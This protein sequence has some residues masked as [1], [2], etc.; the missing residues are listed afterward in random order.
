MVSV[1]SDRYPIQRHGSRS[2]ELCD[3]VVRDAADGGGKP[4]ERICGVAL[5]RFDQGVG[6]GRGFAAYLGADEGVVLSPEGDGAHAAFGRVVVEFKDAVV[7]VWAQA[8]HA[9][10]RLSDC[11][12]QRDFAR[13]RSELHRQPSFQI[14][15]DRIG[16]GPSQ[17][18]ATIRRG[19]SGL[20]L[21]GIKLGYPADGLFGNRGAL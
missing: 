9:R 16:M 20:F 8:V 3:I 10:Q 14:V 1:R 5:G 15:E 12:G 13:D 4:C 11:S 19:A 2:S 17:F 18:C 21:D 6:D 7:E